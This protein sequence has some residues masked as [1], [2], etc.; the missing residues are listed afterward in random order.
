MKTAIRSVILLCTA[1]L[2]LL[3]FAVPAAAE[4]D[5]S[6]ILRVTGT[7]AN[8]NV[9]AISIPYRLYVPEEYDETKTG[10]Y[11]LLV[12]FHDESGAGND[13]LLP[14][15]DAEKT[16]IIHSVVSTSAYAKSMFVLVPQCP[17]ETPWVDAEIENGTYF[18]SEEEGEVSKLFM[19]LL[20]QEILA[21][22]AIGKDCVSLCGISGGAT[23]VYDLC[24]RYP[25]RFASALAISG[26]VD[27]G[28]A[29]KY[30]KT[31]L[32]AF[33]AKDDQEMSCAGLDV[34]RSAAAEDGNLLIRTPEEGG[35]T[36]YKEVF[37]DAENLKWLV[38]FAAP[39]ASTDPENPGETTETTGADTV[40]ET[41]AAEEQTD[42]EN[43]KESEKPEEKSF[44]ERNHISQRTLAIGILAFAVIAGAILLIIG[45]KSGR[46]R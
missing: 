43:K 1:L 22:Y 15:A 33:C 42:A 45:A 16:G 36:L 27:P 25:E 17:E 35:H 8:G 7:Y 26:A 44:F 18:Y 21:K 10:E 12:Y 30:E 34:L 31:H 37:A 13:N 14:I 9:S 5:L 3:S 11:G 46:I 29:E 24:A 4:L 2:L 38:S 39:T 23:M 40:E 6:T 19:E 32:A 20:D 41:T 28:C